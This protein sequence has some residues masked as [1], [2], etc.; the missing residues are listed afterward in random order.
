MKIEVNQERALQH[1][2]DLLAVEGPSGREG[3]VVELIKA[4]FL[5]FGTAASWI[6]VDDVHTRLEED[7]ETGNLIIKFPGT[8]DAPRIM[9]SAHMDTVPICAGAV[10]VIKDGKVVAEGETAVDVII[11]QQA[12]LQRRQRF[13]SEKMGAVIE[14]S[15]SHCA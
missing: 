9:F 13:L 10:P 12:A 8:V 15:F 7:F 2:M 4:K 14:I 5:G 3:K 11:E 6:M 1:L